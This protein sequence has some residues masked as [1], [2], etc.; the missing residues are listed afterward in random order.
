[1]IQFL[2]HER[3]KWGEKRAADNLEGFDLVATGDG[4][5]WN[6]RDEQATRARTLQGWKNAQELI[7]SADYGLIV[8]AEFTYLMGLGWINFTE[9]VEW[10]QAK[11]PTGLHLIITGRDAPAELLEYGGVVTAMTMVRHSH[12]EGRPAQAGVEF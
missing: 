8:L 10:L 12:Q 2:K 5:S 11:K 1:M 9:V 6:S 7:A 4:F 3:G